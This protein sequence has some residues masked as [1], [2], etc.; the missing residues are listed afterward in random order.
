MKIMFSIVIPTLNSKKYIERCLNSIF[1]QSFRNYEVIVID[2][3][4]T[5]G[6]LNLLKKYKKRIRLFRNKN[7]TQSKAINLG[8][9]KSKGKWITWQNSDDFYENENALLSFAKSI[10]INPNKL[11]FTANILL[12]NYQEKI[13]RDVKY[14]EPFFLSLL[15]EDMTM[16]NQACFWNKKIHKK[17]GY[18]KNI[19]I[20]FD[21]EWFL[22]ILK[23]YPNSGHHINEI[24]ACFRLHKNQKTQNQVSKDFLTKTNIKNQYGY[25]KNFS[26]LFK[27]ILFFRRF[28]LYLLQGNF[29]YIL[30]GFIKTLFV[31]KNKEYISN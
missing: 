24:L 17:I 27:F 22:R 14:V 2:G 31:K 9:V 11:L 7:D 20:N 26:Y 3:G 10:S 8:I 4:S 13:L 16:T 23:N 1:K 5:D 30:R 15:Y 12:V 18:L 19:N 6:T 29:Y 28:I 25:K 21:Y